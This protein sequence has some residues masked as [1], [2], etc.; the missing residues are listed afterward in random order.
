MKKPERFFSSEVWLCQTSFLADFCYA[1]VQLAEAP[2][3]QFFFCCA[4][5]RRCGIQSAFGALGMTDC[6]F[7]EK[8]KYQK[9]F[10]LPSCGK[11]KSKDA[12]SAHYG[13]RAFGSPQMCRRILAQV[14]L[15]LQ[16]ATSIWRLQCLHTPSTGLYV[17]FLY[18]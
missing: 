13:F 8:E 18:W 17:I 6:T 16:W 9:I 12:A 3:L 15:P 11:G 10:P 5:E 4:S 1:Q 2:L 7:L 14:V